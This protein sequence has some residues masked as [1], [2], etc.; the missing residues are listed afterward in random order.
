M[1]FAD[2]LT[3]LETKGALKPSRVKDVRTSLRYLAQSLGHTG[4]E[5][6]TVCD[7]CRDPA[8]WTEA[9]QTHFDTLHASGKGVGPVTKKNTRSNIR[10]AFRAA[11][12]L[13][14]LTAPLPSRLLKAPTKQE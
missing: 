5:D 11:E 14:L 4:L 10:A 6:T 9:L 3:T 13:R 2:L 12:G 8:R 1:T 7:A